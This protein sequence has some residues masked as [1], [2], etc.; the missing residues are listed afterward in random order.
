MTCCDNTITR[1]VRLRALSHDVRLHRAPLT[2]RL[3]DVASKGC[4]GSMGPGA[5]RD[6]G[7]CLDLT[8]RLS[9]LR[10]ALRTLPTLSRPLGPNAPR[11]QQQCEHHGVRNQ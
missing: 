3:H 11:P 7:G 6:T 1:S 10:R 2:R 8:E 4:R 9:P 5:P